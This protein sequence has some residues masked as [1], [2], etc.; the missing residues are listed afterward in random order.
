[1]HDGEVTATTVLL[2]AANDRERAA[3]SQAEQNEK[4]A[5]EQR[6][7]AERERDRAEHNF[8]LARDAVDRYHTTVSENRLLKEPGLQPLRKE[9]L[10]AAREFYERFRRERSGDPAVRADLARALF[11]LAAITNEIGSKS[12]A[13]GL[14]R[15]AER[16]ELGE[17]DRLSVR[18]REAH[19]TGG[20]LQLAAPARLIQWR[21]KGFEI[22]GAIEVAEGFDKADNSVDQRSGRQEPELGIGEP[23]GEINENARVMMRGI[24]VQEA[25]NIF[26]DLLGIK[27]G[28]VWLVRPD[29]YV[30][31]VL[32][33]PNKE[34]LADAVA[35]ATQLRNPLDV[36]SPM[37]WRSAALSYW[38]STHSTG[39]SAVSDTI[40]RPLTCRRR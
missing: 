14:D 25:D 40:I 12:E 15:E 9:L 3:R 16:A 39:A 17:A 5:Q 30:S 7:A 6:A 27:P 1:M 28:E 2:T 32:S 19:L 10:G 35:V 4:D 24:K 31:A 22:L 20:I 34:Q 8:K 18:L 13:L 37:S 38:S 36:P 29:A 11:R 33:N 26:G 21:E 23:V